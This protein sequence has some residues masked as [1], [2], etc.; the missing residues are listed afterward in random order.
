MRYTESINIWA[1]SIPKFGAGV[2]VLTIYV[3][4]GLKM[5]TKLLTRYE[6]LHL[7]FEKYRLNVPRERVGRVV[8]KC[9]HS[10]RSKENKIV[11]YVKRNFEA[12]IIRYKK[13]GRENCKVKTLYEHLRK[14]ETEN[15]WIKTM[16][17][18]K[19]HRKDEDK[20]G[21]EKDDYG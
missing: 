19:I 11:Q 13:I 21:R 20:I 4:N 15:I 6:I 12:V 7:T 9:E 5:K 14:I 2:I 8:I 3:V 17:H 1:V 18:E 10:I 16:M